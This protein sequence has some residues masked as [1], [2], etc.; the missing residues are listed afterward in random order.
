MSN[1]FKVDFIGIGTERAATTW[2]SQCLREH[3]E[4]CF[5]KN[6]ELY[7]FNK[8]DRH[9]LKIPSHRYERG[10]EWY[11]SQFNYRQD[12]LITGEFS[13]TYMYC[14]EAAERIKK[15]FPNVKLI[16]CLRNPVQRAFSQ[17]LHN[18]A[19]G[20]I[21]KNLSFEE[22][23]IKHDSYIKK[24][25]YFRYLKKYLKIFH[26]ENIKIIFLEDIVKDPRKQL[27]GVYKFLGVKNVDFQPPSLNEKI[28]VAARLFGSLKDWEYAN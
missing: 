18:L 2:L 1:N 5:S 16:V 20:L 15:H 7:F 12:K 17:Y 6:K 26:G 11:S 13:P 10:I 25:F 21:G 24:G 23:M 14:P 22:A 4:I 27:R 9:F 28:N 8:L 3:P 19:Q